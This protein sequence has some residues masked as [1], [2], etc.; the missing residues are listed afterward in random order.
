MLFKMKYLLATL[1]LSSFNLFAQES[2]SPDFKETTGINK[3]LE[4][5][6]LPEMVKPESKAFKELIYLQKEM[7]NAFKVPQKDQI[8]E[9]YE[10]FFGEEGFKFGIESVKQFLSTSEKDWIHLFNENNMMKAFYFG[11][12]EVHAPLR[13]QLNQKS[14]TNKDIKKL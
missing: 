2:Q 9:K 5:K 11:L 12:Y 4:A 8:V 1:L 10:K 6:V 3:S 7:R 13:D 14:D